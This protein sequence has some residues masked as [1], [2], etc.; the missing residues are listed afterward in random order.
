MAFLDDPNVLL[1]HLRHSFITSDDT[2]KILLRHLEFSELFTSLINDHPKGISEL[3]MI[4]EDVDKE[5]KNE[6]TFHQRASKLS[7]KLYT[8]QH[9]SS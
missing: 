2:G 5:I 4:T 1:S 6:K 7:R 9:N 3:V 8:Q